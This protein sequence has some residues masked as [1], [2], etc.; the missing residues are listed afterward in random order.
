MDDF[1]DYIDEIH[2]DYS[3]M[4]GLLLDTVTEK[5]QQP[6]RTRSVNTLQHDLTLVVLV[7]ACVVI[8]PV[9]VG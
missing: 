4:P 1:N 9:C 3:T 7:Q 6:H 2:T 5:Y 8:L